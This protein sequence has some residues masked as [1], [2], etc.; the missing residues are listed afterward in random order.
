MH[1]Y[2]AKTLDT[3]K[4]RNNSEPIFLQAVGEVLTTLDPMLE[5]HPEIADLN[6]LERMCEPER[7][8][9]FRVV[10]KGDDGNVHVTRGFRIEFSSVLGPYKGGLRFQPVVNMGVMKF[11][12]FEQ[13]F[14]NS[15]T[16]LNIGGGKGGA[17]FDPHGK[18]DDEMMRFCQAFMSELYR[19][20]GAQRDVPAGDMGVG[21]R[22]IGYLFGQYKRLTNRYELGVLTGKGVGWGGSQARTE[23]TGYGVIYFAQEMLN[24][25]GDDLK[26]KRAVVSGA[27]NVAT[28]AIKKLQD[29]GAKVVACSDST[30]TLYHEEGLDVSTIKHL[31]EVERKHIDAYLAVHKDAVFR[32]NT[33]VW[34]VPCDVAFPCATQNELDGDDARV[35]IDND[36]RLVCEG[37]NMPCTPE[38]MLAFREAG[39]LFGP[40]KAANAGGVAVSALEM[41]QN[42]GLER[43]TFQQVD[44][45]LHKI[46]R[47]IFTQCTH[48]AKKYSTPTDYVT[49][50]NIAGFLRVA[51]AMVS[52]GLI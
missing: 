9:I 15:L 29:M 2:I 32:P 50:A 27:G 52:H 41:Q 46:M 33:K 8:L 7:Q 34:N 44:E 48:C 49:G 24:A 35:L 23:A 3:V 39:V 19:H 18:S 45:E 43:W 1:P 47:G 30:G 16:G 38:A 37:A 13:V 42:A 26:G 14:K 21:A 28:Y 51:Q 4:K 12:G 22:E 6:L 11:L 25:A 10:W 36:V 20:I 17:E 5:E 31:A 40:A